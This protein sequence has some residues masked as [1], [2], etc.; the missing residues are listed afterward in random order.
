MIGDGSEGIK[1]STLM[2]GKTVIELVWIFPELDFFSKLKSV[3]TY[4]LTGFHMKNKFSSENV[5]IRKSFLEIILGDF[6]KYIFYVSIV[7]HC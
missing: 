6:F 1:S 3:S 7:I 4:L 5:L 2:I